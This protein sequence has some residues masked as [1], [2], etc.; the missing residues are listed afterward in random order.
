M[1]ATRTATSPWQCVHFKCKQG[2]IRPHRNSARNQ[3][4]YGN[5]LLLLFLLVLLVALLVLVLLLLVVVV[6]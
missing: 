5:M 6:V 2:L 1:P 3:N 4:G